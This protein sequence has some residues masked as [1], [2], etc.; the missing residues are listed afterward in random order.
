MVS[1]GVPGNLFRQYRL[2]TVQNLS[3]NATANFLGQQNRAAQNSRQ[4]YQCLESFISK[5]MRE[6]IVEEIGTY[7]MAGTP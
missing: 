3:D 5:D 7:L 6:N 2:L 4:L 1:G